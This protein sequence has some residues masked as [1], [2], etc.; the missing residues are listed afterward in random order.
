MTLIL[1]GT[2]TPVGAAP[3]GRR[4]KIWDGAAIALAAVPDVVGLYQ[5]K[6]SLGSM[7]WPQINNLVKGVISQTEEIDDDV[8]GLKE[9]FES[10][11]IAYISTVVVLGLM[12]VGALVLICLNFA[13]LRELFG[14][15]RN[16]L[17][18]NL[19]GIRKTLQEFVKIRKMSVGDVEGPQNPTYCYPPV[20]PYFNPGA[21]RQMNYSCVAPHDF[22]PRSQPTAPHVPSAAAP[23][24]KQ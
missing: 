9:G 3:K 16:G 15:A 5:G 19:E 20:N 23:P 7:T 8:M 24:P 18:S 2:R 1:Y 13:R 12:V 17:P 10:H 22:G 11:G 4:A 6:T 14:K 21:P